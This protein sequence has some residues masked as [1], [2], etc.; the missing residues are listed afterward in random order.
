MRG[1]T[2]DSILRRRKAGGLVWTLAAVGLSACATVDP[3]GTVETTARTLAA[4]GVVGVEW[5]RDESA[6]VAALARSRALLAEPLTAERASEVALLRSPALQA[7][8]AGL[9]I[10]QADLAQSTRLAN[11]GIS[12]SSQRG[13]GHEQ[14]TSALLADLVDWLTQP[15]RR[16][17]A[18]AELE[19]TK[20]AVGA[21][22]LAQVT[23]AKLALVAYQAGEEVVV[24]LARVEQLDRAAADYAQTLLVAGN[25]TPRQRANAE[26]GWAETRAELDLARAEVARRREAVVR[27]LGLGGD[28]AWRAAPLVG[29]PTAPSDPPA[30]LEALA[31]RERLDLAAARWAVDALERARRLRQR[32]RWLPAGVEVA[33]ERERD[34]EGVTIGGPRVELALPV[35]DSGRASLARYDAEIARARDQLA[36]VEGAIRSQVREKEG[37]LRAACELAAHYRDTVLPLR[38]Q[39]LDQT[40]REYNQMVIGTFD[41]LIASQEEIAAEKRYVESLAGAWSARFELD[42]ALGTMLAGSE[43]GR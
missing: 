37:D 41:V 19:R 33:I 10:A 22:I 11:P 34:I 4:K 6:R 39:V 27:V 40:L 17:V 16:R 1:P 26:A 2:A 42:R 43:G 12:F 28:E 18:E 24:R 13:G 38:L 36:A 20:L 7:T 25:L 21:A 8:L 9:G 35:F 32:T 5:R 15:L 31:V 14:V 23:E 29:L 30:A 3:T